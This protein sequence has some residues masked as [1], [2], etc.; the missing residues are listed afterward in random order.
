M[1]G[2]QKTYYP[3]QADLTSRWFIVDAK[4]K[5]LG[6]LAT[7]VARVLRGKHRP[8]YTPGVN[9]GDHVVVI[10]AKD[11]VVTGGKRGGKV[12]DTYSG[13]PSGRKPRSYEAAV[14][15]DATFPF[16][17]AVEGMLQHNTLGRD[18]A[19]RL[20]VYAGAEHGHAAQKPVLIE[21]GKLGEIIEKEKNS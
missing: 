4:G 18:M 19:K 2:I 6:R 5:T 21:F 17:H 7:N 1:I 10:N 9:T 15:R 12:Y 16:R 13:Y 20:R 8:Q 3:K 11:L 14:E